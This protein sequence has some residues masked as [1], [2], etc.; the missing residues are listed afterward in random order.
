MLSYKDQQN[1]NFSEDCFCLET[2][3]D[4]LKFF[5]GW[6]LY[7]G[8]APEDSWAEI[9]NLAKALGYF[10]KLLLNNLLNFLCF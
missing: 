7:F 4:V 3:S 9:F 2:Q 6:Y 8:L 5:F 1:T 10:F